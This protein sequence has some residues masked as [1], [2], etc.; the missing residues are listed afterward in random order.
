[1]TRTRAFVLAV[2]RCGVR[3]D[4]AGTLPMPWDALAFT[5]SGPDASG[6][7]LAAMWVLRRQR[8]ATD[9]D[10]IFSG[11]VRGGRVILITWRGCGRSALAHTLRESCPELARQFSAL[12]ERGP[13]TTAA[14]RQAARLMTRTQRA[15]SAGAHLHHRPRAGPSGR[16][17]GALAPEV[18]AGRGGASHPMSSARRN[19]RSAWE[20][21]RAATAASG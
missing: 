1:M 18:A 5:G 3:R 16:V 4:L 17:L 15:T 2:E 10:D 11:R 9:P 12:M 13:V 8:A 7:K 21:G 14:L 6:E 19:A 20:I